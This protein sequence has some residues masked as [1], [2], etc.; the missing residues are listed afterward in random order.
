[1]RNFVKNAKAI[2]VL[3]GK[4]NLLVFVF[5]TIVSIIY[6]KKSLNNMF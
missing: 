5:T 1:M 2:I 3:N 4:K 6:N